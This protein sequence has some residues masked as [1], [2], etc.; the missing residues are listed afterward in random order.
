M[1]TIIQP[2]IIETNVQFSGVGLSQRE[3]SRTTGVSEGAISKALCC[4]QESI[5]LSQGVTWAPIEENPTKE[6]H[7]L[8]RIS[9]WNNFLSV[10]QNQG[11]ADQTNCMP[12]HCPQGPRTFSSGWISPKTS[13]LMPQTDPSSSLPYVDRHAPKQV[14]STLDSFD[15]R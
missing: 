7:V 13:R 5:G 6:G 9:R 3:M 11:G 10:V 8:L 1:P 15:F 14:P 4:V 12:S 2:V